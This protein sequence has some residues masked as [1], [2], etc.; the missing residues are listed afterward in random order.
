[1]EEDLFLTF[2]WERDA[3]PQCCASSLLSTSA[4][5]LQLSSVTKP[6]S[7]SWQSTC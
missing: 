3:T 5:S 1:M 7:A 6:L 2:A 4:G